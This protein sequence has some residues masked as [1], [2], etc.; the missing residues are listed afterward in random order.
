[1]IKN[2]FLILISFILFAFRTFAQ[3]DEGCPKLTDRKAIKLY[4]EAFGYFQD[5]HSAQAVPLF[6]D[7]IQI[8]PGVADPY[9]FLGYINFKLNENY[10]AA[11]TYLLK[12]IEICP[13]VDIY[14]YYF[15]GDIYA[16]RE[17]WAKA[18]QYLSEF[19]KDPALIDNDGD[20][21]RAKDLLKW[22][23]FYDN[24]LN[25]PVSFDPHY[26][27]GICSVNHEYLPC[28]SS[29]GEIA[30]YTRVLEMPPRKDDIYQQKY[31]KE[32]LF[33]S[34]L[35]NGKFTNGQE[36]PYPFNSTENIGSVT[37]TLDNN[38]LFV[39]VGKTLA[40]GYL[41]VDIYDS[42]KDAE[43]YW[44]T[45]DTVPNING[46]RTWETQPSISSDGKTL[47]FVSDRAGGFGAGDIWCS[48]MNNK[49]EWS[50]P[51]NLG[52]S[53]NTPGEEKT[54]FIHTDSQTLYFTSGD[55]KDPD[56][57][58]T[59]VGW[60]G[61]GGLDIFFSKHHEDGS[62]TKPVNIGYPINTVAD[63]SG[64]SVSTSGKIGYYTSNKLNGPGGYDVY[65]FD[66]YKEARPEEV[67]LIKG[68]VTQRGDTNKPV[69]ARIEIKNVI[70]KKITEIPV[71]SVT[72]KYV[73]ALIFKNDYILTVKTEDCAYESKYLKKEDSSYVELTKVDFEVKPIVVGDSYRLNDIFFATKSS[74][75]ND[76]SRSV[77]DGFIIFLK[78][79]P[80]IKVS[81]QGHTDN[82]GKPEDNL[83]LSEDRAKSVYEYLIANAIDAARLSYKGF[84][85]GK[86][87]TTND[88]PEGKARNRRTEFVIIEK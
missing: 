34:D 50:K 24:M 55:A 36:M 62:W 13:E 57:N 72:G 77:L 40:D 2:I 76:E 11:E 86:P 75:L 17:E 18:V 27:T 80:K 31:F 45:L 28:I 56:G 52:P 47:Y 5:K 83:K 82:V 19:V 46:R 15:L 23:K 79:N 33:Y 51:E 88:T 65:A 37:V 9:Y 78:E 68:E 54:P 39:A 3:E 38:H 85:E 70:T 81:I 8:E 7:V 59:G 20:L 43:G 58:V 21:N 66:L 64:F 16:G 71:D 49:G 73:A 35:V 44:N 74:E 87:I 42:Y 4:K 67:S 63:E 14:A 12:A 84:G 61:V 32:A 53:I 60:P 25:H 10:K 30:F 41:N 26:I 6:K 1:M 29:D 48:H 69:K 22:A